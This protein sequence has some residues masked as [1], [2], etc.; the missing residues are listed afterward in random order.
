MVGI[1]KELLYLILTSFHG[2]YYYFYFIGEERGL[3]RWL[4]KAKKPKRGR[5]KTVSSAEIRRQVNARL[6][7]E[8]LPEQK[9]SGL[10]M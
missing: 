7:L 9:G 10:G 2:K 4:P 6:R 3:E 8:G 1:L 5:A